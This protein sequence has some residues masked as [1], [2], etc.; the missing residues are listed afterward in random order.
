[1][2]KGI[3]SQTCRFTGMV[4][5]DVEFVDSPSTDQLENAIDLIETSIR[6]AVPEVRRIYI[7]AE[8]IKIR[9]PRKNQAVRLHPKKTKT[10]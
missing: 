5:A 9:L 2:R 7:E 3:K 10:V 1:M 8:P 4:N 6:E